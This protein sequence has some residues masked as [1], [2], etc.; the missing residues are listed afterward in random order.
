MAEIIS[1][2]PSRGSKAAR[3]STRIDMTPMVDLG[4]LLITFFIFTTSMSA[5]HTTGL[6]MPADGAPMPTKKSRVMTLLLGANNK[7]F[8][9]EGDWM[10][11]KKANA[12][13][14]T[15]YHSGQGAGKWIRKKQATLDRLNAREELMLLIKP[16]EAAQYR[17]VV[18]MLDEVMINGVTR[19]AIVDPQPGERAYAA[20]H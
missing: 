18:D 20:V 11:A 10:D 5:P 6:I 16:L 9:Y 8:V 13:H 12:I 1:N 7:V 19:Y 4:F 17:N 2:A 3:K 14:R 15:S